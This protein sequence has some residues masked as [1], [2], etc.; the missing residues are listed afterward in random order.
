M[1]RKLLAASLLVALLGAVPVEA[2]EGVKPPHEKWS[3]DG[4]FGTFDRASLQ[5]GWQVYTEV[6]AACHPVNQLYYRDL[7][8][9]GFNEDEVKAIAAQK[10]TQDG[11]ND[12]GA[13]FERPARPSDR[14][15]RPFPNEKAAR[16]SNNGALPPDLS[17]I[18]KAREHG[19]D[20]VHAVLIGYAEPPAGIKVPDGM[21]YNKYFP[22]HM[23]AMPQPLN[24]GS[25]TYADNTKATVEQ[26]AHD[27]TTFL[28]WAAEPT[29]EERKRTGFKVILF[30]VI[31][32]ILFYAAKRRIWRELH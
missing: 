19:T 4:I 28:T 24:E 17:L 16:A 30:V 15:A 8:A 21:N 11:P 12:E 5:R 29:L 32:S 14:I 25:V 20:Y 13:M 31:A 27:V 9:L 22:G 26:M 3:F 1:M 6:C 7:A 2:S 23:I 10:Q 18:T